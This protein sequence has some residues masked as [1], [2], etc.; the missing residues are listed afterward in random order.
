MLQNRELAN[1]SAAIPTNGKTLYQRAVGFTMLASNNKVSSDINT[2][3]RISSTPK[4]FT[5]TIIFQL[6]DEK[7]I[8]SGYKIGYILSAVTQFK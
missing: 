7:E 5:A 4:M 1:G 2:E 6:I 3:Y 8:K